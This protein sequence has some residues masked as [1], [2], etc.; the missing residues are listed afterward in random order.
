MTAQYLRNVALNV[1][2]TD[3]NLDLSQMRFRFNVKAADSQTP[4]STII[5]IYNLSDQTAQSIEKEYT[6][7][8]LQCGYGDE[9]GV[10]FDGTIKQ[11]RRGRESP[12][13]TYLD[14]LAADG[15]VGLNDTIISKSI[16]AG[17]TPA[18]RIKSAIDAMAKSG[19]SLGYLP[20]TES[21]ALARGV[22]QYGM[23]RDILRSEVAGAGMSYSIQNGQL[24]FIPL[25][26]FLP[27]EEVVLTAV[28]G[29]IGLPEQ[30]E[31]G[32]KVRCLINPRL[33]I[34]SK[35]KI[36]NKSI[37]SLPPQNLSASG[38][39]AFQ[40]T[41]LTA[42]L[43]SDGSYRIYVLEHTGDTRG[44]DWYSD[45]VCLAVQRSSNSVKAYG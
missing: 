45:L 2:S 1:L 19:V 21:V 10:I 39:T 18:D 17:S 6:R 31:Y 37:Q 12:V 22:V 34:G 35:L 20:E 8:V 28:T 33:G 9:L 32:V 3:K 26:G 16:A 15:D 30:T 40:S 14:I 4:N 5:R 44:N 29:M 13:D 27:G 43:N 7:V 24:I 38:Q 11:V 42:P 23:A 41:L 36:D 25:D